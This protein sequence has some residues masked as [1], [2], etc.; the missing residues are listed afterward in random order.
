[1]QKGKF[2][3]VS[4]FLNGLREG[5]KAVTE[6]G[7]AGQLTAYGTLAGTASEELEA[8]KKFTTEKENR[9][10]AQIPEETVRVA[11]HLAA[12]REHGLKKASFSMDPLLHAETLQY[13]CHF[14]GGMED[15]IAKQQMLQKAL[16]IKE[17]HFG[18][19]HWRVA[20]TL[21]TLA[22]ACSK[23]KNHRTQKEQIFKEHFGEEHF[24]V[25]R[26]WANVGIAYRNLGQYEKAKE[27]F[28]RALKI[29]EQHY[30]QDH[31]EVARTLTNLA[32][33]YGEL[34]D[35]DKA[36][37][38][39]ER[40]LKIN[41]RHYGHGSVEVAITLS[42]LARAHG[43]LG[44]YKEAAEMLQRVLPVFEDHFGAH[45]DWCN[46]VRQALDEATRSK[47]CVRV[48]MVTRLQLLLA[49]TRR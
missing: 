42:N 14:D 10:K 24:T 7:Y 22:V 29:Q 40:A 17:R 15:P 28:E 21:D 31:F 3:P 19:H 13:L 37:D 6:P 34:K 20:I 44:E 35:Y 5:Y 11:L 16:A 33:A 48:P 4:G 27:L 32:T 12:S 45:H 46:D 26:T 38:V 1:M 9:E 18:M 39:L 25:T 30:G 23:F 8:F 49:A 41:E 36:K 2:R 43:K 47:W